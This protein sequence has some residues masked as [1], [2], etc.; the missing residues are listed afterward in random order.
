MMFEARVTVDLDDHK[1]VLVRIGNTKLELSVWDD[2][3]FHLWRSDPHGVSAM[4][5]MPL[6]TGRVQ[7][8]ED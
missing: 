6:Y 7:V 2:G 1:G 8:E 3:E 4:T 5:N